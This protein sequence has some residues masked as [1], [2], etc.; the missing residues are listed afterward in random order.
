[1]LHSAL[2]KGLLIFL[3]LAKNL[4]DKKFL[5][6]G[7][8]TL[9]AKFK[10]EGR[11]NIEVIPWQTD[12]SGLYQKTKILIVPSLWEESCPR[13]IIEAMY[14]GIPII[15]NDVGGI[16]AAMHGSDYLIPVD[17]TKRQRIDFFTNTFYHKKTILSYIKTIKSLDDEQTYQ[18]A[19]TAVQQYGSIVIKHDE[20]NFC[21]FNTWVQKELKKCKKTKTNMKNPIS[22]S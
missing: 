1:M 8:A 15:T 22:M 7:D 14:Y 21:L 9:K 19:K 18:I 6:V 5:L 12:I 13:T 16:R 2:C 3:N 10:K 11:T 20:K 17:E 4:P